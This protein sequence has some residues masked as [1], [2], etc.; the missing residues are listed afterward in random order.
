M[1]SQGGLQG[2]KPGRVPLVAVA[3][4]AWMAGFGLAG[5]DGVAPG[6]PGAA[7][8]YDYGTVCINHYGNRVP[9]SDCAHAPTVVTHDHWRPGD[10]EDEW[11]YIPAGQPYPAI[12]RPAFGG[13]RNTGKLTIPVGG[14][15]PARAAVIQRGGGAPLAGGTVQRGGFGVSSGS[16]GGSGS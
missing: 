6:D 13:T 4:A 11:Y 15:E 1:T 3:A 5:C 10:A 7:T 2:G 12:G 9:D 16:K 8:S 14:G